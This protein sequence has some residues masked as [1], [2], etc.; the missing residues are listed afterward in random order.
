MEPGRRISIH[1][2]T[3]LTYPGIRSLSV[4]YIG[5]SLLKVLSLTIAGMS[6]FDALTHTF[7]AIATIG[8]VG[9]GFGEISSLNNYHD[10]PSLAKGILSVNMLMGRLELFSILSLF[11]FKSWK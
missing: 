8:N 1:I 4:V 7:A 2:T 6:V 11:Y 3:V 9:P 5:L 10:L